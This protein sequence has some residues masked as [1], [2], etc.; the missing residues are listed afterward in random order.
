[1]FQ[2]NS[3][4]WTIFLVSLFIREPLVTY[5][6][7]PSIDK[8]TKAVPF[9]TSSNKFFL[10]W[11]VQHRND[12]ITGWVDG[13][14]SFLVWLSHLFSN[15]E[16]NLIFKWV[17]VLPGRSPSAQGSEKVEMNSM[18]CLCSIHEGRKIIKGALFL[19][20][21]GR[22]VQCVVIVLCVCVFLKVSCDGKFN[23]YRIVR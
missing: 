23:L 12:L 2:N 4:L 8:A 15:N 7:S 17:H 16:S 13:R 18:N 6:T 22:M 9:P 14:K 11:N 1:M 3:R 20:V 10:S 21:V 5:L 19:R